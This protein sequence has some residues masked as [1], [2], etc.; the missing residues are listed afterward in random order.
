MTIEIADKTGSGFDVSTPKPTSH[1]P[2][3]GKMTKADF[4]ILRDAEDALADHVRM[5]DERP[6]MDRLVALLRLTTQMLRKHA[7]TGERFPLG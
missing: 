3:S 4:A 7:G 1:W 6:S 5:T 2:V